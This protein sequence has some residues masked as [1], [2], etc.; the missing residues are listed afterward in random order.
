MNNS[1]ILKVITIVFLTNILAF[2]TPAHAALIEVPGLIHLWS[3]DGN[4]ND[5][6]GTANGTLGA[7]TAFE[8]GLYDEAFS[9][10]GS[11]AAVSVFPVNISPSQY[12]LMTIGMYVNVDS[13]VNSRGWILGHDNGGYDRALMISDSRFNSRLSG[14]AGSNGPY[15]SSLTDF[16]ARLDQWFGIAVSYDHSNNVAMVYVND[17]QGNSMIQTIRTNMGEGNAFFTLGGLSNFSGH[18]VDALVDELFIYDRALTQT[19]LDIA[20]TQVSEPSLLTLVTVSIAGLF[21]VQR[22]RRK[23]QNS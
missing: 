17:L 11:Q 5:S 16:S 4:A 1:S 8:S 7:N 13:V 21:A 9:F 10:D 19:E 22:R 18:T 23:T 6:V 12:P 2:M 14:T 3:G 15:S 20:F